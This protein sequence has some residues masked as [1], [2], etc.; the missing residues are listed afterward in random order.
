MYKLY[1]RAI[2]DLTLPFLGI[3]YTGSVVAADR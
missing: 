3:A 1:S 2:D